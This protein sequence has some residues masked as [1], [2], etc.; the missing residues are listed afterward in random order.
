MDSSPRSMRICITRPPPRWWPEGLPRYENNRAMEF[1]AEHHIVP[2]SRAVAQEFEQLRSTLARWADVHV[3][4]F[5]EDLD[6]AQPPRHDFVFCR[7]SFIAGPGGKIVMASFQERLR[8]REAEHYLRSLRELGYDPILAPVDAHI[9]GGEVFYL[10]GDDMLISGLNRANRAGIRFLAET[11]GT[12]RVYTFPT[13]A[14]HLDT[15]FCPV[16][17]RDARLVAVLAFTEFFTPSGQEALEAFA[18]ETGV[19]V[20]PVHPEDSVGPVVGNRRD[21]VEDVWVPP[22]S[23]DRPEDRAKF[24]RESRRA[25]SL[26]QYCVNCLSLPG[27]LIGTSHF[28][29]PGVEDRL[30]DLGIQHVT[31]PLTQYRYSAGG[32]HCATNELPG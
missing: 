11:F 29:S 30:Q 15:S 5:P 28:V 14:F 6:R 10:P 24:Q 21:H 12:S 26:G 16:L 22:A 23:L 20:L 18:A 3:F 7:D 27:V 2:S 17:D 31:T 4:D 32:V 19:E 13:L 1:A 25:R 9:E 8:N